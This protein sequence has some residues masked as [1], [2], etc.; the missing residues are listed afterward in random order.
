MTWTNIIEKAAKALD[1][2]N[3]RDSVGGLATPTEFAYFNEKDQMALLWRSLWPG[4]A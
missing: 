2:R 1:Y 3:Y 4:P